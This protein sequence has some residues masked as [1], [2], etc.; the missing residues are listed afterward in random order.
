MYV[1]CDVSAS[2]ADLSCVE[3]AAQERQSDNGRDTFL[4]SKRREAVF[5][6]YAAD[7]L[8]GRI[9]CT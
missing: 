1:E 4:I 9:S 2:H 8:L 3:F 6:K 7:T 5:Y